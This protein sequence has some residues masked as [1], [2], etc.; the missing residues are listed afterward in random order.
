LPCLFAFLDILS[1]LGLF[2]EGFTHWLSSLTLID[3]LAIFWPLLLF[4][5]LRS[6]GKSVFLLGYEVWQ[7]LARPKFDKSFRPGLSL[8]IPAHNEEKIIVRSIESAL[9]ADYEG[10][11]IIVVDDGSEDRTYELAL[12]YARRGL[13][14]LLHRDVASGSKAGA[15]NYGLLFAS[16][17][18]IVTVDA[19]TVLER[20][21]LKEIVK[22]LSDNSISAVSGN[23]RVLRGENGANNLLVRL[24]AYEYVI[25]LELGRRFNSAIGTL[26]MISGAFGAFWRKNVASIGQYDKDTI[27]EDFDMTVKMRKLGKRLFFSEGAVCWTFAPE[28]WRDWRRQR[29]RWTRGQIET[30]WKHANI[31]GLKGFD[32]RLIASVYD[33]LLMDTVLL[34]GRFAWLLLIVVFYQ[35]TIVYIMLVSMLMYLLIEFVTIA[36]A[37][38][39]SRRKS[40]FGSILLVPIVVLFY[41]PYYSLIRLRAYVDWALGRESRW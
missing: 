7:E 40:D 6:V 21:S 26:L 39:L 41:R 11:E 38:T 25:S 28:T 9:E 17:D 13:I 3:F 31:F 23:V 2:V 36:T 30:L 8:V 22:P 18:V 5:F 19:D 10:K 4:D 29:I 27:T 34:F 32:L 15:L 33:M 14:K 12:P 20:G 35:P 37:I 16:G 24:Q 1:S